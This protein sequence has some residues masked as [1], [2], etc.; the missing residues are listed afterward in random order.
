MSYKI[1]STIELFH[2]IKSSMSSFIKGKISLVNVLMLIVIG[3]F[4]ITGIILGFTFYLK[5]TQHAIQSAYETLDSISSLIE[6][7][8]NTI[9][10]ERIKELNFLKDEIEM[11]NKIKPEIISHFLQSFDDGISIT[12]EIGIVRRAWPKN[13]EVLIG[14]DV[15]FRDYFKKPKETLRPYLSGSFKSLVNTNTVVLGI[16]IIKNGLFKG[17]IA[18]GMLLKG[19]KI[20]Y[21]ISSTKF[22]NTGEI[23]IVDEK[24]TILFHK[25]PTQLGRIFT[26]FPIDVVG[27]RECWIDGKEYLVGIRKMQDSSWRIVVYID[28]DTILRH[29]RE[30]LRFSLFSSIIL[31]IVVIILVILILG[32]ILNPLVYITNL[33]EEYGTGNY[34]KSPPTSRYREISEFANAFNEMRSAIREREA[35]IREETSY[36]DA[37]LN[38]ITDG[39]FVLDLKG[40]FS[41]I[42]PQLAKILGYTKEELLQNTILELFPPEERAKIAIQLN[43]CLNGEV[44]STKTEMLSKDGTLVP[45]LL[46]SKAL[47]IGDNIVGTLHVITDLQ[48]INT[49][50][51]ELQDALEE[52]N[53]LNE[54]LNERGQQLEIAL[55]RLNMRLFEVELAKDNVEKLAI[56]DP[57]THLYNRRFFEEKFGD[58]L[59]KAE[60]YKLSLS[61]IMLDIDHFKLV[62]DTYGHKVGDK[63]LEVLA[64]ILKANVREKDIVTRY[65]GD[66]FVVLLPGT[67]KPAAEK[68]AERIRKEIE[69]TPLTEVGGP[70]KF[71]ASFG[72]SGFPEDGEEL[73][74]L[75]LKVD[76]ALYDAKKLGRNRVVVY[77]NG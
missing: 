56:T 21:L 43:E 67:D 41:F 35:K 74:D 55:A 28:R 9:I 18:G 65:G 15:S 54:E 75:L 6:E 69:E 24:K 48:E 31:V 77:Q 60:A 53:V 20:N 37:L 71:T 70:E 16:P 4:I 63:V 44:K 52:I 46:A 2:K 29:T 50:E 1:R 42:N 30:S 11:G 26:K 33:A 25:D 27:Y 49:R 64:L 13:R 17:V 3:S 58:E 19:G 8:I 22:L 47:K 66:E 5:N 7:S 12:D 14:Q 73:N 45:V 59:L 76:Q 57:L 23:V 40:K 10:A 36:L 32:K 61:L 38:Q 51:K 34:S 39:V 72:V 68:V 62:N